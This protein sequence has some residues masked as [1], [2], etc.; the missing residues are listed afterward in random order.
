MMDIEAEIFQDYSIDEIKQGFF[1]DER[2]YTCLICGERFE[3]GEIYSFADR[4]YEGKIAVKLHI[5]HKHQSVKEVLLNMNANN[6]GI[7]EL[8]LQLLNFFAKGMSDKEIA[9][10]LG[11]SGSTIR[12]HRHK[13]RERERQNKIFIS[14]MELLEE[15]GLGRIAAQLDRNKVDITEEN[16][17]SDKERKR[18]LDKYMTESGRLK[19]YPNYERSKRVVLE[20]ILVNFCLGTKYTEEEINHIL[21]SIYIDYKL[22][23]HE[24]IAYN[25][26]DRT[27]T[28]AIYWVK[29]YSKKYDEIA[30][31]LASN[32][33]VLEECLEQIAK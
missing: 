24:L 14:L 5:K 1:E 28:G 30:E 7:S 26:L 18:I 25:Y 16:T 3:K 8:Q 31:N 17:V 29:N 13:L 9:E 22:L 2:G 19:A 32:P 15:D 33:Q 21:K 10:Y 27:T 11:V 6:M 12:N 4:L 20:A 23:K